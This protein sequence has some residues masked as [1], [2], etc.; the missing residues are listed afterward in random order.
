MAMGRI[1]SMV[2][3]QT[4]AVVLPAETKKE[5]MATESN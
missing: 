4:S 3:T 1:A 5:A 2:L